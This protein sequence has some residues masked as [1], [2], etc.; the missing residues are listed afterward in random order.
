M[1]KRVKKKLQ[2][3]KAENNYVLDIFCE[4]TFLNQT[5]SMVE[6]KG[7]KVQIKC[8]IC[9]KRDINNDNGIVYKFQG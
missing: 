6:E 7:R 5:R 4:V 9:E 3:E 1:M 8:T 2:Q